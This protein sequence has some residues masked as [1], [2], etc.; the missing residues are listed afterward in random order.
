MKCCNSFA[1]KY[2]VPFFHVSD[3][4]SLISI[5][6]TTLVEFAPN[7]S[8]DVDLCR[9]W[10]CS[11]FEEDKAGWYRSIEILMV[12]ESFNIFALDQ[13]EQLL[14]SLSP[15][16]SCFARILC[17]ELQTASLWNQIV[18]V[19]KSLRWNVSV[20]TSE[21]IIRRFVRYLRSIQFVWYFLFFS[22][23]VTAG[24]LKTVIMRYWFMRALVAA[25][26]DSYSVSW[27]YISPEKHLMFPFIVFCLSI[28][29]GQTEKMELIGTTRRTKEEIEI[30]EES[31]E[32]R[33][34][35]S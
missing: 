11:F 32:I 27:K 2:A 13:T 34:L 25:C 23:R 4:F 5:F 15:V 29:H 22:L 12:G 6:M 20:K 8:T 35:I 31:M 10:P 26:P 18:V 19:L 16:P 24:K 28:G 30:H 9:I 33:I 21:I 3:W 7:Q 1:W 17:A 14:T